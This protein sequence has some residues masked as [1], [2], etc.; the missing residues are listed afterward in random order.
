M[1]TIRVPEHKVILC[2]EFG[3]GKSSLFRRYTADTFVTATDRKST[4]GLD[5]YEKLYSTQF[6]DVKV[7]YCIT[8][9]I[10]L[11][12]KYFYLKKN[13]NLLC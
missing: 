13:E 2:G 7:S 10:P 4:L 3:V 8:F 5:H 9:D 12:S 6:R 1:A 11:E